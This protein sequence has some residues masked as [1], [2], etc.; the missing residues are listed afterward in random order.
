M[1]GGKAPRTGNSE[2]QLSLHH[3]LLGP[4][5][6]S[7]DQSSL[8]PLAIGEGLPDVDMSQGVGGSPQ[9]PNFAFLLSL[10]SCRCLPMTKTNKKPEDKEAWVMLSEMLR[11]LL[12]PLCTVYMLMTIRFLSEFLEFQFSELNFNFLLGIS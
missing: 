2:K 1:R 9:N 7:S 3:C 12:F 10:L 5:R 4:E 6:G 8:K 11:S